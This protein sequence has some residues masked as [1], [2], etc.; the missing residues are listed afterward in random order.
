MDVIG[1][2]INKINNALINPYLQKSGEVFKIDFEQIPLVR[3]SGLM[4]FL[5]RPTHDIMFGLRDLREFVTRWIPSL[6]N[7]IRKLPSI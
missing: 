6:N 2:F 1:K 5:V 3:L 7:Y 4:L